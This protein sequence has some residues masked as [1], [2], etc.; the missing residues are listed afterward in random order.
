MGK[1]IY[2][3]LARH[4]SALGMGGPQ[5]EESVEILFENFT[6]EEAEAALAIPTKTIPFELTTLRKFNGL[7][8]DDLNIETSFDLLRRSLDS[9]GK[10]GYIGDKF[11]QI[12]IQGRQG[13]HGEA[14]LS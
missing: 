10:R 12:G 1:E 9:M 7:M 11:R 2:K 5:K 4:L 8:F 6:P 14:L 13:T 3:T